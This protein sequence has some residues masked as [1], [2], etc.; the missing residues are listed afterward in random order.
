MGSCCIRSDAETGG[1]TGQTLYQ[2]RNV[3]QVGPSPSDTATARAQ[4]EEEEREQRRE[5]REQHSR[6]YRGTMDNTLSYMLLPYV[7]F[8]QYLQYKYH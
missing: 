7:Q 3:G 4:R 1:G 6:A 2:R 5:E 8:A